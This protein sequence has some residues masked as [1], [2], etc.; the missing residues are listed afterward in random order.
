M[1]LSVFVTISCRA[2]H[3]ISGVAQASEALIWAFYFITVDRNL[4]GNAGP[5]CLRGK[6]PQS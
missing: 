6:S 1:G 5:G 3:V 4:K 2:L